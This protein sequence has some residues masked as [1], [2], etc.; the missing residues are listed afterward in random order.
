MPR[1]NPP[2]S[3]W[4]TVS[5]LPGYPLPTQHLRLTP[6]VSW[7]AIFPSNFSPAANGMRCNCLQRDVRKVR[8]VEGV[9]GAGR[10]CEGV[11]TRGQHGSAAGMGMGETEAPGWGGGCYQLSFQQD[12]FEGR[13]E[14]LVHTEALEPCSC[15]FL[16]GPLPAIPSTEHV[17]EAH[18]AQTSPHQTPNSPGKETEI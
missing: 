12:A 3:R 9:P 13:Q 6:S 5:L 2:R 1:S 18:R 14:V 15:S 4:E 16:W 17:C 8:V 11:S 7:K 10:G